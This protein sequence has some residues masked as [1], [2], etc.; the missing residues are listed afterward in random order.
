MY[1]K[2]LKFI[3]GD[4]E[5]IDIKNRINGMM[6]RDIHQQGGF[7][8]IRSLYFDSPTYTCCAENES[9]ISTREKY[10]LRTYDCNEDVILAEIKIRHRDTISKMS[11]RISRELFDALASCNRQRA[12]DALKSAVDKAAAPDDRRVLEKYLTRIMAEAYSPACIV[13]YE[14]SA[15]VYDIGNVRITFDRNVF[16][17]QEYDRMFDPTLTG[18]PALDMGCHILEIK[19][20]EFLPDE[21]AAVLGGLHLTRSSSSKYVQSMMRFR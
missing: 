7:Y 8:R 20:D 6:R 19:Y 18:R 16:A 21:I 2:E 14:R 10:R 1:R 9:G 3:K 13:D 12:T 5:L 4:D 17:T 15:F 11:T